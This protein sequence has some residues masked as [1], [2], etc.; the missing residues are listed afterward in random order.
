MDTKSQPLESKAIKKQP[1]CYE[2]SSIQAMVAQML[3]PYLL[4]FTWSFEN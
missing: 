1:L 4:I 2:Q 3:I